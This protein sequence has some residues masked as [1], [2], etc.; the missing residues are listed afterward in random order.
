MGDDLSG[1]YVYALVI[2]L[3]GEFSVGL[4]FPKLSIVEDRLNIMGFFGFRRNTSS[5][6]ERFMLDLT[7]ESN[8]N[9]KTFTLCDHVSYCESRTV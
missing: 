4:Q 9:G 7:C 2:N 8:A 1:Q 3:Q 6:G 5:S